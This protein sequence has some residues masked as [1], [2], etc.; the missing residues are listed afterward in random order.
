MELFQVILL[1]LINIHLLML[2]FDR[3]KAGGSLLWFLAFLL[4]IREIYLR[5]LQGL[6]LSLTLK[7]L[8]LKHVA[9][10]CFQIFEIKLFCFVNNICDLVHD[11]ETTWPRLTANSIWKYLLKYESCPKKTAFCNF[12]G[13][14]LTS[15]KDFQILIAVNEAANRA[16]GHT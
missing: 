15:E 10:Q 16:L 6:G 14:T 2:H 4:L 11:V 5:L 12:P 3:S 1:H 9:N 7:R 13:I 8:L